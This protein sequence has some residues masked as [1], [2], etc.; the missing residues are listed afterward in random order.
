MDSLNEN[1]NVLSDE[2]SF[3]KVKNIDTNSNETL[4]KSVKNV[5]RLY[6]GNEFNK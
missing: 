6:I 4:M 1:E 5:T 3:I 2:D